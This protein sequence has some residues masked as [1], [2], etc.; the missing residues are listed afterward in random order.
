MNFLDDH[1]YDPTEIY[2]DEFLEDIQKIPDPTAKPR[3][4]LQDFSIILET[5]G[6]WCADR[7][8]LSLL[9]LAEKLKI[10]TPYERH[11]L[12]LNMIASV[13]IKI[14]AICDYEF[15]NIPEK[16][17]ILNYSSPKVHRLLEALK[18]FTSFHDKN[19]KKCISNSK[20]VP[21]KYHKF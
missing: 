1:R 6:P 16:S 14:R 5:L 20:C 13:M 9:V 17:K 15:R 10:K 18:T 4:M 8:A 11:Y 21:C 2:Q 12:L 19:N 7:A 3:E